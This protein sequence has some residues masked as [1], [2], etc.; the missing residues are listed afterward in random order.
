[1]AVVRVVQYK[2]DS[3]GEYAAKENLTVLRVGTVEDRPE[4]CERLDIGQECLDR[5]LR[6]VLARELAGHVEG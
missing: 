3:C 6:Q 5:P 4:D 1:M 2:C